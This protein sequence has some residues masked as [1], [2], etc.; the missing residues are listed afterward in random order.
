MQHSWEADRAAGERNAA[1]GLVKGPR[2]LL[3][4]PS[5]VGA[6]ATEMK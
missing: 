3:F 4:P 2:H 6:A 5:T 1:A